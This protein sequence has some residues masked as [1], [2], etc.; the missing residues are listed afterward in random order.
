MAQICLVCAGVCLQTKVW[1][2]VS[3]DIGQQRMLSKGQ[4]K[5]SEDLTYCL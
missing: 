1:K 4:L 3:C 2:F 5:S